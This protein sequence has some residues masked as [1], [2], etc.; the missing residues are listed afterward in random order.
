MVSNQRQISSSLLKIGRQ[1]CMQLQQ[2]G[3]WRPAGDAML[4]A[5]DIVVFIDRSVFCSHY[6][7]NL[8]SRYISLIQQN[9]RQFVH[10]GKISDSTTQNKLRNIPWTSSGNLDFFGFLSA[11]N[12]NC[13]VIP[14]SNGYFRV[15][16]THGKTAVIVVCAR[17][18][19]VPSF[20]CSCSIWE[21]MWDSDSSDIS[22]QAYH[23]AYMTACDFEH[24]LPVGY[25]S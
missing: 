4:A 23:T 5:T 2:A 1:A 18:Y 14:R 21:T 16:R 22:S 19:S 20:R 13:M 7:A 11:G 3:G 24:V 15:V 9:S 6:I 25:D 12:C 8:R 17:K 10:V